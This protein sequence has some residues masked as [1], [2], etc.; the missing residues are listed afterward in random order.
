ME[1]LFEFFST[2]IGMAIITAG[3][4]VLFGL[5]YLLAKNYKDSQ[6]RMDL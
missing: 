5:I 2:P 6:D 1:S 3:V 4:P